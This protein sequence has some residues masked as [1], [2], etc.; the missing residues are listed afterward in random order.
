V[1]KVLVVDD[2]FGIGEV[3]SAILE[4]DGHEAIL[5]INGR[6]A[7]ERLAEE[8]VDLILTDFMMP[9]IDGPGLVRAVLA[10]DRLAGIPVVIM[11]SL[12]EARVAAAVQGHVA[13]LRKPFRVDAVSALIEG[14]LKSARRG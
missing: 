2:E 12:P 6:Q 11:S 3:L 13:F 1:A 7:L 14:V 4:D 9:D 5:A 8:T 10:D